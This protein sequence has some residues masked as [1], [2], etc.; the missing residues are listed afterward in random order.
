MSLINHACGG[1]I[2]D[3]ETI[4]TAAHC[5][6]M[7]EFDERIW[8]RS[9]YGYYHDFE[10]RRIQAGITQKSSY[11]GQ[12]IPIIKI[13]IHP[14]YNG[15]DDF[16]STDAAIIKL[17]SP[18]IFNSDVQ[19]ACLPDLDF[20]P[21][22][23]GEMAFIRLVDSSIS[24]FPIEQFLTNQPKMYTWYVLSLLKATLH[25]GIR[26]YLILF[27]VSNFLTLA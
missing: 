24:L 14:D 2:L 25:C 23:T 4:L 10:D 27:Q 6:S 26:G 9:E 19:P 13:I 22:K 20:A 21:E 5:F 12:K 11:W 7:S 18:L 1:T 3:E 17:E 8:E 15:F 16:G